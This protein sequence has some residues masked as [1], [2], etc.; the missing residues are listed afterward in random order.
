LFLGVLGFG[1]RDMAIG[2]S[3]GF[4]SGVEGGDRDRL[5]HAFDHK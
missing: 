4:G 3:Q 1:G 5:K 2:K